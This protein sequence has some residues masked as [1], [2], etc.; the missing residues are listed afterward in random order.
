MSGEPIHV[1]SFTVVESSNMEWANDDGTVTCPSGEE[2]T[3]VEYEP[4]SDANE[5][6]IHALGAAD[7]TDMKYRLRYGGNEISF[8]AESP[9]GG[10]NAPFSFTDDLGAPLSAGGSSIMFNAVNEGAEDR[11]LA[12]RFYLEVR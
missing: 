6:R 8:T 11:D 7:A 4:P 9:L 3:L 5:V 1:R 10:I 12:G 2:T